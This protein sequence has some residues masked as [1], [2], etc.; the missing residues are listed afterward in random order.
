MKLLVG[1]GNPGQEYENTLHNAGFRAIN[2]LANNLGS[3]NWTNNF[4]GLVVKSRFR[5]EPFLLLKPQTYMNIS[6]ESLVACKSYFKIEIEDVMVLSDDLDL[7]LGTI[8]YREKGG[9]GGHNGLRSII[10]LCGSNEFHRIKIGIG[11]PKNSGEKVSSY[12]L[13]RPSREIQKVLESSIEQTIEYQMNFI[14]GEPIQ[15]HSQNANKSGSF[16]EK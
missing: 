2:A 13:N 11:R 6:G 3:T 1:L 8:R 14:L 10:Q 7:P 9:H 4:K 12:V 5:G 15:V 16:G